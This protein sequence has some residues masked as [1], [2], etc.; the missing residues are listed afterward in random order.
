MLCP[1]LLYSDDMKGYEIT[2]NECV[3][4]MS[5]RLEAELKSALCDPAAVRMPAD[6]LKIVVWYLIP[7]PTR[8]D[9]TMHDRDPA[10]YSAWFLTMETPGKPGPVSDDEDSK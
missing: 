4:E 7:G 1:S 10:E 6:V 2:K 3:K 5:P 8:R 9:T